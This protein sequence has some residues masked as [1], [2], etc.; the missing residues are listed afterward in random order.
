MEFIK[1]ANSQ[2]INGNAD[3][4]NG[5]NQTYT[6]KGR[7]EVTRAKMVREVK[8]GKHTGVHV[9]K[10]NGTEYVRANPNE[11]KKDNVDK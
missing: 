11:R 5:E 10:V 8:N 4:E 9:Q 3:G 2:N 7:G 1:M 6:V